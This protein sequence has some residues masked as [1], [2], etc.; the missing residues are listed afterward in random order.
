MF[1]SSPFS[2]LDA[3]NSFSSFRRACSLAFNL[4]LKSSTWRSLPLKRC[5][6]CCSSLSRLRNALRTLLTASCGL[7]SAAC[8]AG[9]KER[10][11][12]SP[13]CSRPRVLASWI[14]RS[15][16]CALTLNTVIVR[17]KLLGIRPIFAGYCATH[18]RAQPRV[19]RSRPLRPPVECCAQSLLRI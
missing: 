19:A 3:F 1:Y 17:N 12:V 18:S 11:R 6:N 8:P 7:T 16:F 4:A 5:S 9:D 14:L 10:E 15:A 13:F 2:L